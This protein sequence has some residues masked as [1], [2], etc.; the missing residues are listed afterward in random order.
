VSEVPFPFPRL[1]A[2][3]GEAFVAGVAQELAVAK[4]ADYPSESGMDDSI[5]SEEGMEFHA[6]PL[7]YTVFKA[8]VIY[9][10][11]D[12]MRDHLSHAFHTF[13]VFAFVGFKDQA[14][15]PVA[16]EDFVRLLCAA[17]ESGRL[18]NR[19]I[20]VME[21]ETLT[22]RQAVRRVAQVV[23][24][25]PPMF[26]LPLWYHYPFAALVE[27]VMKVPMVSVAQVRM[28][29]EGLAEPHL[30]CEMPP[31]DLAPVIDFT[32]AQIRKGLPEPKPFSRADFI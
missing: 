3:Y 15:R 2:I 22:L 20:A 19:T 16:V 26:P 12:H 5:R 13:P 10:P 8:G 25:R 28:L 23:G 11:G 24:K 27:R 17:V 9:G 14:I 21:P 31:D 1:S 7:D 29:S 32:D 4:A 18:A 30:P 6:L